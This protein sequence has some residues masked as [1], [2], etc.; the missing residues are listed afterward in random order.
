M[1]FRLGA[2]IVC[3]LLALPGCR[4]VSSPPPAKPPFALTS[5][6]VAM[7]AELLSMFPIGSSVGAADAALTQCGFER[8]SGRL[9]GNGQLRY[10]FNRTIAWPVSEGWHVVLDHA[11]EKLVDVHVVH[12]HIGP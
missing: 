7:R 5:D 1:R 11:D 2:V 4:G 6:T 8:A 10:E 3:F 12:G 9:A